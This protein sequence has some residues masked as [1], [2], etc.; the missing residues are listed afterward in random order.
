MSMMLVR[1]ISE[2][3]DQRVGLRSSCSTIRGGQVLISVSNSFLGPAAGEQTKNLHGQ[4][5]NVIFSRVS[6][7]PPGDT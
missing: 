2:I 5:R 3:S 6:W 7:H 4:L 1:W